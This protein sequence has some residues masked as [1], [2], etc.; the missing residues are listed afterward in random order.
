MHVDNEFPGPDI[1]IRFQLQLE[2]FGRNTIWEK[3]LVAGNISDRV[4]PNIYELTT[5]FSVNV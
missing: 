5:V 3:Q 1:C 4:E 2:Q